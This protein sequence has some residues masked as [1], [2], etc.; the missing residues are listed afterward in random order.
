MSESQI[1]QQERN[2]EVSEKQETLM[3]Q[4]NI[5]EDWYD[6]PI[7]DDCQFNELN[8]WVDVTVNNSMSFEEVKKRLQEAIENN[9][10]ANNDNYD[11]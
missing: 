5:H 7:S 11:R 6:H 2:M 3:E 10:F 1:D 9:Q 4:N 8:V